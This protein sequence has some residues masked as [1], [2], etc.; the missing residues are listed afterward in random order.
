MISLL[1]RFFQYRRLARQIRTERPCLRRLKGN[2]LLQRYIDVCLIEYR[3]RD[4]I[5]EASLLTSDQYGGY[6]QF[7][8]SPSALSVEVL[9]YL[10]PA[11]DVSQLRPQD[12]RRNQS[13]YPERMDWKAIPLAWAVMELNWLERKLVDFYRKAERKGAIRRDKEAFL[14]NT[15]SACRQEVARLTQQRREQ[16]G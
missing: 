1:K 9:L 8:P 4:L 2:V 12:P 13:P 14:I 7:P 10:N 11:A 6:L 15:I 3:E 5:F 16:S